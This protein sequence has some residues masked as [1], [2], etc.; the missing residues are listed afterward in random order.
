[1]NW[2]SLPPLSA[3]EEANRAVAA[4]DKKTTTARRGPPSQA[5]W[6][7]HTGPVVP[8]STG[9][10]SQ[11]LFW[12]LFLP[13]LSAWKWSFD[14]QY[15][16]MRFI[17]GK[18]FPLCGIMFYSADLHSTQHMKPRSHRQLQ[19]FT[20]LHSRGGGNEAIW[21]LSLHTYIHTASSPES[22][23]VTVYSSRGMSNGAYW[24]VRM[25]WKS[26]STSSTPSFKIETFTQWVW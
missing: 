16:T 24:S 15:M 3:V 23:M 5:E 1:M 21:T 9:F 4:L 6:W 19:C 13:N 12:N 17:P 20:P 8:V 14:L 22:T 10:C 2:S 18:K 25:R 7:D 11:T 26:S